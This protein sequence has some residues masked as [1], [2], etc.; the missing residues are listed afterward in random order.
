MW[1]GVILKFVI[2]FIVKLCRGYK[3]YFLE[4]LLALILSCDALWGY[5]SALVQ[6]HAV[7]TF[8]SRSNTSAVN[9][10]SI[11]PIKYTVRQN[12][13]PFSLNKCSSFSVVWHKG[14]CQGY[15]ESL[16]LSALLHEVFMACEKPELCKDMN[17]VKRS[18]S[19]HCLTL[20]H[21]EISVVLVVRYFRLNFRNWNPE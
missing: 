15:D 1:G 21:V 4:T 9:Y 3:L 14:L 12:G 20:F 19:V 6:V 16:K 8:V 10:T 18:I 5:T 13:V 11:L 2:I 17:S 7:V